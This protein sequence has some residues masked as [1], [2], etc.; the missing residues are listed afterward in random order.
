MT[1]RLGS[2]LVRAGL[3]AGI[4]AATAFAPVAQAQEIE[5]IVVSARKRTETLQTVP[6]SVSAVTSDTIVN[7]NLQDFSDIDTGTVGSARKRCRRCRYRCP[8]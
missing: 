1:K 4:A 7:L 3:V 2:G 5:E 6:V 8:P